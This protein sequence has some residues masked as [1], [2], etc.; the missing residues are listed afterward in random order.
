MQWQAGG[1]YLM[2]QRAFA[3][4]LT[5]SD[6]H[7]RPIW[8]QLPGGLP[9]FTLAGSPIQIAIQM[10]DVAPARRRFCSAISGR[11]TRSL[12]GGRRRC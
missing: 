5:M 12:T 3:L 6:A 2:N 1:S 9:G 8:G 11:P 10:P 7:A 4:L